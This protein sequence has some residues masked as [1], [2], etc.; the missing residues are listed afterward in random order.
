MDFERIDL[1]EKEKN[2]ESDDVLGHDPIKYDDGVYICPK[3]GEVV[4]QFPIGSEDY[5]RN[6]FIEYERTF[7]RGNAKFIT[8]GQKGYI[9]G[10]ESET[11]FFNKYGEG[12]ID[13]YRELTGLTTAMNRGTQEQCED[14]IRKLREYRKKH[15][16][17]YSDVKPA[18]PKKKFII[19]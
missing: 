10:T 13:E 6:L 11:T 17:L 5:H 14:G 3:R 1:S 7:G 15:S 19:E 2:K 12:V 4:P 18:G 8:H 16:G 9:S